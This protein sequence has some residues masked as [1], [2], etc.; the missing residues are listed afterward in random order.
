MLTLPSS[1]KVHLATRPTDMRKGFDGLAGLVRGLLQQDP[2]SG[3]LFV[4]YG[5]RR[6]RLKILFWDQGGFVLYAKRFEQG[7]FPIP[8]FQEGAAS[9]EIS[10]SDLAML[11]EGI[12]FADIRRPRLWRPRP[13]RGRLSA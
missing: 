3:H 1:V 9:Q 4:F 5:R 12:A 13:G 6:D 2:F 8:S 7:R 10:P 11:L